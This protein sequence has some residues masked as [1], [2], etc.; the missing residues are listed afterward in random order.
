MEKKNVAIIVLA[1]VLVASGVGNVILGMGAVNIAPPPQPSTFL[2]GTGDGPVT[3]DPIDSWDSAS[4][5]VIAQVAECLFWY[6]LTDS[7]LPLEPLL[8]ESYSWDGTN[9]NLTINV[10]DHVYF[11]D[12]S[13]LDA[14]VVKWNMDRINYFINATGTLPATTTPAFPSSL[15]YMPDGISPMMNRTEII[16]DMTLVIVLNQPFGAFIPLLSY[17]GS[18]II[19]M[20]SHSATEYIDLTDGVLI[21]TGPY[22]YDYYRTDIEV[23][24]TRFDRYWGTNGFFERFVLVIIEETSTRNQ[25]MLGHTVDMIYGADQD[26]LEQFIAD[27][28]SVVIETGPDLMYW[29]YAFDSYRV[30]VTWREAISKAYNYTYVIDEIRQGNAIRGPPAVPAGLPGHDPTV[31]VAQYNISAAREAMQSMGFGVGWDVG[32]HV[33]EVFTPGAD[34]ALWTTANFRQIEMNHH[35]GSGNSR[36][37]NDLLSF[38]LDKIGITTNETIRD[39]DQFLEA[40]EHGSLRGIWYVGWGPDYVDAFNMLDPLFNPASASNFVNLTDAQCVSWLTSIASETNLT[41]RYDLFSKLQHRLY[42]ELYVHMTLWATLGRVV[43]GADIKDF[44]YN[45]MTNLVVWP[46]YRG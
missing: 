33:G 27:P 21:G 42:E 26:L 46:I 1:V 25:A 7:D 12:G 35:Q 19:S 6:D 3:I 31:V 30:N 13:K 11:H 8:A 32:T 28:E 17:T 38:D 29:Y 34:E 20:E 45:P 10:R 37:L 14:A 39:W 4:N 40:G 41:I 36:K 9:T 24:F 44:P 23:R 22:M 5:D 43:H 15:Y 16:D 18:A 2:L